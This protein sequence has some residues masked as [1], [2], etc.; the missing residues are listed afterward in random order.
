MKNNQ[1]QISINTLKGIIKK[2][3]D[4]L[5]KDDSL[6]A[7]IILEQVIPTDT[8]NGN[9]VLN[10]YQVSAYQ[11]CN[12]KLI[13]EGNKNLLKQHLIFNNYEIKIEW[14]EGENRASISYYD[15]EKNEQITRWE[16][17]GKMSQAIITSM[18][19]AFCE[20]TKLTKW[21]Y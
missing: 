19:D 2:V 7:T 18:V 15:T 3:E 21:S 10:V 4:N 17:I 20:Y 14:F 11:E 8:L 12:S 9:D 5:L 13:Y 16:D 6:S 1:I